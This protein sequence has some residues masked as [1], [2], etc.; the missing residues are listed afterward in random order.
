MSMAGLVDESRRVGV[1]I[2]VVLAAALGSSLL[3]CWILSGIIAAPIAR[4]VMSLTSQ[5]DHVDK[6]ATQIAGAADS[7]AQGA[8][9]QASSLEEASSALTQLT[10]ATRSNAESAAS[11]NK[12][13]AEVRGG[14]ES[15]DQTM[16]QLNDAM[17]AIGDSS[18]RVRKIIKVIE[19]IAF[20][21]NLLA[22][23]AAVEAARAGEHGKGFAVVAEEVRNLAQRSA[24][25]AHETTALI[26]ESVDR[27][28]D[29]LS[30]AGSAGESLKSIGAGVVRVADLLSDICMASAEQA[31]G[32]E[33]IDGAVSQLDRVTQQNAAT[34][35]ESAT[36]AKGL[37]GQS[38]MLRDAVS[39]LGKLV[40]IDAGRAAA[41][42]R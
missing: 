13:A 30:V 31:R 8:S 27:A 19:E 24:E 28:K 25:A 41:P 22:L 39:E 36:E 18:N 26:A 4:T 15:A 34:A 14:V 11:A 33:Q 23:N 5:A 1:I 21:T 7:L 6:S 42:S 29:G 37:N 20:Q 12:L 16:A 9:E 38:N 17:R 35:D 10:A 2:W 32:A 40:G 3:I